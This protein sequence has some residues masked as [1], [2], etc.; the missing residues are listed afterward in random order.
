MGERDWDRSG[1]EEMLTG[2][3]LRMDIGSTCQNLITLNRP[4][5]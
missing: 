1:A 4:Q 5:F 3:T 2:Q